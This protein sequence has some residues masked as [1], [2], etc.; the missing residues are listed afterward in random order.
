MVS[1]ELP[2]YYRLE[3]FF[4]ISDVNP[5]KNIWYPQHVIPGENFHGIP[6]AMKRDGKQDFSELLR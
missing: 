6:F 3:I 4:N 5:E 2:E 1:E